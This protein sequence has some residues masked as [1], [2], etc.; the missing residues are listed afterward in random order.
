MSHA[1]WIKSVQ[2]YLLAH[3]RE[4]T[5][6]RQVR[7]T[8]AT[9]LMLYS[10]ILEW[11]ITD[12]LEQRDRYATG[13]IY[14]TLADGQGTTTSLTTTPT[15]RS[16]HLSPSKSASP[17]S[18]HQ[19]KRISNN[20]SAVPRAALSSALNTQECVKLVGSPIQIVLPSICQKAG[21]YKRCCVGTTCSE[22]AP[23]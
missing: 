14:T 10:R 9:I 2:G 19:P 5:R 11:C 6:E 3:T 7:T 18:P 22:N 15:Y 8:A 16:I 17:A 21:R 20:I 12:L 1:A 23:A 4:H 13:H